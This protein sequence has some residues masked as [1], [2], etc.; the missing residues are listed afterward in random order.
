MTGNKFEQMHGQ[1]GNI[2][3]LKIN[4]K[5]KSIFLMKIGKTNRFL[6]F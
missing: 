6:E 5:N 4:F 3:N 2:S 1:T